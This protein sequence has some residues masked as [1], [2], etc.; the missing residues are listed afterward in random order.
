MFFFA[1][2][3]TLLDI[4]VIPGIISHSPTLWWT[5]LSRIIL[6]QLLILMPHMMASYSPFWFWRHAFSKCFAPNFN[7]SVLKTRRIKNAKQKGNKS[8]VISDDRNEMS[9]KTQNLEQIII[10]VIFKCPQS[11]NNIKAK[12]LSPQQKPHCVVGR[13]R[14]KKKRARGLF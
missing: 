2:W 13:L 9:S 11:A 10:Q 14:R 6:A 12:P 5:S 4:I 3:S 8:K 7:F 1:C